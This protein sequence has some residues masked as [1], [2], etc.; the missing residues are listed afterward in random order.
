MKLARVRAEW[1]KKKKADKAA[2]TKRAGRTTATT[3]PRRPTKSKAQKLAEVKAQ[4]PKAE[5]KDYKETV[6]GECD[7][8]STCAPGMILLVMSLA[9]L[10]FLYTLTS[11]KGFLY[12]TPAETVRPESATII[13]ET[14]APTE[15][16]FVDTATS[17]STDLET[18]LLGAL[19]VTTMVLKDW[20]RQGARAVLSYTES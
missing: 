8:L 11:L 5:N 2:E 1:D 17:T 12:E 10:V 19:H 15:I 6:E 4:W 7:G 3:T 14:N 20:I 16:K 18:S 9:A 13:D